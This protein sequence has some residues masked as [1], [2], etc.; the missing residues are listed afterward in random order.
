MQ[1]RISWMNRRV[2]RTCWLLWRVESRRDTAGYLTYH[3]AQAIR[4]AVSRGLTACT[5]IPCWE[6]AR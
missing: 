5:N 2:R 6:S 4:I 1:A 3:G